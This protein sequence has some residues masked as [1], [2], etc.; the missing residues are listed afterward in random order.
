MTTGVDCA[1]KHDIILYPR[2]SYLFEVNYAARVT[3]ILFSTM[4]YKY[5]TKSVVHSQETHVL[6]LTS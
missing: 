2:Y 6:N 4:F 1:I 3:S 5:C